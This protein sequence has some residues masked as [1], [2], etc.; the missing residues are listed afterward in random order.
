MLKVFF[1][2]IMCILHDNYSLVF[3]I[4][5]LVIILVL[6]FFCWSWIFFH[7]YFNISS[8]DYITIIIFSWLR[9]IHDS[10]HKSDGVFIMTLHG[11]LLFSWLTICIFHEELFCQNT[12]VLV[13]CFHDC[14]YLTFTILYHIWSFIRYCIAA[15]ASCITDSTYFFALYIIMQETEG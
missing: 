8:H 12:F 15:A 6:F 14:W 4:I 1:K 5:C 11:H 3:V 13:A 2:P 10:I 7:D 9:Y